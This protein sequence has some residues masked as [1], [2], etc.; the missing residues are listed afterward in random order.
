METMEELKTYTYEQLTDEAKENVKQWWWEHGAE[1]EWWDC[2]Y[3][4]FKEDGKALGFDVGKINFS[5]FYSQGDG[6]CWSGQ[7]DVVVW[8]RAHCEDSIARDAWCQL[9]NEGWADKQLP[10]GYSNNHYSHSGTMSVSYWE[11]LIGDPDS[12]KDLEPEHQ[13][14]Q[15]DT[16]F[17]SMSALDLLN[18]ITSSDFLYTNMAD[19][20]EAIEQSARDYA[21]ELYKRLRE[22]YEYI[23][24]EANLIEMCDINDWKF[25]EG[26]RMA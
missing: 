7:I 15:R 3:E 24:S 5:G 26:G 13:L 6:A 19:I 10:V 4:D 8:L 22:E 1:Y 14:M 23:T 11:G 21:D 2:A 9:I 17:K 12:I 20:A 16:I 18:L 25:D